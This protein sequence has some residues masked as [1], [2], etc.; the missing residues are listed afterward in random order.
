MKEG[1]EEEGRGK[2]KSRQ[3]ERRNTINNRE[4]EDRDCKSLAN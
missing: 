3:E 2:Q 4:E 1:G